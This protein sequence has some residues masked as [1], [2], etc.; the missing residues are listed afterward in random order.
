MLEKA[1]ALERRYEELNAQM[2]DPA[3]SSDLA[4]LADLARE[5]AELEELVT[6]LPRL[7]RGG[8]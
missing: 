7:S 8:E 2:A 1:A 5:Q 3:A 4:R 6:V